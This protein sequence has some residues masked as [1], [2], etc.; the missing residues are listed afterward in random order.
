MKGLHAEEGFVGGNHLRA[1][2]RGRRMLAMERR[3]EQQRM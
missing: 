3:Q 2:S 1:S